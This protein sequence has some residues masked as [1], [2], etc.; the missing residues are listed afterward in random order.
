MALT[1]PLSRE[2][3]EYKALLYRIFIPILAPMPV[4]GEGRNLSDG[5]NGIR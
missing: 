5:A 3:R 4:K 1:P 2:E